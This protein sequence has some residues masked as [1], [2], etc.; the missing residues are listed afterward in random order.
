V[1]IAAKQIQDYLDVFN[2]P[3]LAF[4]FEVTDIEWIEDKLLEFVAKSTA[5][6]PI[7]TQNTKAA[8]VTSVISN[9]LNDT[10]KAKQQEAALEC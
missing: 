3:K 1:E 7:Q 6:H 5:S 4:K 10:S 9:D 8:A 2:E